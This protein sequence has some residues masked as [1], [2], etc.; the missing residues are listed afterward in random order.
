MILHTEE[1]TN[2]KGFYEES[3]VFNG[4]MTAVH[5]SRAA[6]NLVK[7]IEGLPAIK[8][9]L[10]ISESLRTLQEKEEADQ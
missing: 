10:D 4:I 7:R 9:M 3:D 1:Y 2:T 6:R 5:L 8:A